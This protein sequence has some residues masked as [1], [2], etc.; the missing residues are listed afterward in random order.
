[1]KYSL[2]RAKDEEKALGHTD[3][4]Q[5]KASGERRIPEARMARSWNVGISSLMAL[6]VGA[7]NTYPSNA[8]GESHHLEKAA[9]EVLLP[10]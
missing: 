2:E 3:A 10:H 5:E 1:M 4:R 8:P 9:R 6:C 7:G